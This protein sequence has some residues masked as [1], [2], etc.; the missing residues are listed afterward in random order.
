MV[1]Q[2]LAEGIWWIGGTM[3]TTDSEVLGGK[4]VPL[5]LCC[6]QKTGNNRQGCRMV[7]SLRLH[8]GFM[9]TLSVLLIRK[10]R[11]QLHMPQASDNPHFSESMGVA[12][13]RHVHKK[14][15]YYSQL[16]HRS[17]LPKLGQY[18]YLHTSVSLWTV[19]NASDISHTYT[20]VADVFECKTLENSLTTHEIAL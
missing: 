19:T 16:L 4:P 9:K 3:L 14:S 6:S 18:N 17:L 10:A 8:I 20:A 12:L 11:L 5:P 7:E 1:P 13:W 2:M 15:Q